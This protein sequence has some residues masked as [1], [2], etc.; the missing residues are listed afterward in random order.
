M[1]I[2]EFGGKIVVLQPGSSVISATPVLQL[3]NIINEE[4]TAGGERGLVNVVAD[5]AFATN[6]FI[7]IF[8]T[9][10]S[11]Q[12]DRVSRFT[13]VG[14]TASLS[15]EL[16][17][18]QGVA[19]ST[20][21]DHH[22][23]G[24]GFGPDGKLYITTGDNGVPSSVQ[25]LTGDHGKILRYNKD[26]TIPTDNPFYDG[27]GANLDA[28]W[29]R[30]LRNPYR[31]SFDPP[32]GRMFIGDVGGGSVEEL[33]LGQAGANY[34]WPTCEGPCGTAGMT[35]PI[36][37]YSH[38]GRDAAITG[39]FVYRGTQFPSAYQG[40]YFYGDF[41]QNWLR[42][43]TLDASNVATSNNNFVPNNGALDSPFDPIMLKPGPDGSVYYIDFGWGWLSTQNP[44][45]IRRVRYVVGNQ[46]PVAL[47]SATPISGNA[48]LSVSFSS[49]GSSDP[50]NQP[51]TYL[52]TFGDG[53]QSTQANPAHVY[54]QPG[55]Y[56]AQ[57]AVSD[58]LNTTLA[59][60]LVIRVGNPPTGVITAPAN[61]LTFSA[62]N[63]LTFSG[64]GSD[65]E[66]GTLPAS[67]FSWTVLFRHDTHAHPAMSVSGVTSGTFTIPSSGH[68][69]SGAT[70]YEFIL[71]VTD[72]AGH[73]HTSSVIVNP[74]KVNL[75]FA[76][77][78]AGLSVSIDGV[79]R[80]TP[81]VKDTLTGFQHTIEAPAQVVGSLSYSFSSWS[82]G[83]AQS[84]SIVVPAAD[85]TYTAAFQSAAPPTGL[86]A[87]YS[88]NEASGTTVADSSGSN[89]TGTI[90]G[91]T[92]VTTGKFGG[93]LSF[94]GVNDWVTVNDSATLDL[95]TG[96]TLE[97]WVNPASLGTA[98]RNVLIKERPNGEIY[99]LYAHTDLNRPVVYVT[100]A[101]AP[102][103]PLE[104]QGTAAIPLNTWTH[105]ATTYDGTT[106]R[107][108]VNGTQV[109]TRAVSGAM[110]TSTGALRIG[111]NA[112]WG[113][114]FAGL[115]D[116]VRI[117]NRAL[118][119]AEILG[120]STRPITP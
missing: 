68:D 36:F 12:R 84:H 50:E 13:M 116:E 110:L 99:N 37:S 57:L 81:F 118:T 103:Q 48:P 88:F 28:I 108:Y 119:A 11:P 26:G 45:A 1:L 53:T 89:Q 74:R 83:G 85:Q 104:A 79:P 109:G 49:A 73:Q 47:A 22:G 20:S 27:A 97:A 32:T 5:P 17:I 38:G 98:W 65:P 61:G 92:R 35:N 67:A 7:Y 69:F 54:A 58:G 51:L 42:Y 55:D 87:A 6:G 114:Y 102:T 44:A 30:G 107:L 41:A 3:T 91:A 34:G 10:G 70:S 82:D 66:D 24:L 2:T 111:G 14:N 19:N 77:N 78:P 15:S 33:N 100:R 71:T 16:V 39:G 4:V 115:I 23:G 29:A 86:V 64:T 18:W 59:T 31:F 9:A 60:L 43:L 101:S 75:T 76:T 25:S 120:D 93:A 72:S 94:D 106:L 8:Y 105:L 56:A 90:S 117:Y 113:E 46:P 52:W 96:M 112:V 80:Q 63:V 95:T 40:A 21:T 62:G